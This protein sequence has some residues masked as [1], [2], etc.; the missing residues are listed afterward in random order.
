[1]IRRR[2]VDSGRARGV[3][4]KHPDRVAVPDRYTSQLWWQWYDAPFV[5]L[6]PSQRNGR[7]DAG[8]TSAALPVGIALLHRSTRAHPGG[9]R[10]VGGLGADAACRL[11]HCGTRR[12]L[13]SASRRPG[14]LARHVRQRE[15]HR[16]RIDEP[17]VGLARLPPRARGT[18]RTS[19]CA[20]ATLP[21]GAIC[22]TRTEDKGAAHGSVLLGTWPVRRPVADAVQRC[23]SS[24]RP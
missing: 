9:R 8:T 24:G 4:V 1:M 22:L 11:E 10:E 13:A 21:A 6:P 14:V 3:V 2:V 5:A 19:S 23:L 7:A 18:A 15:E 20:I 17:I 16:S 12:L